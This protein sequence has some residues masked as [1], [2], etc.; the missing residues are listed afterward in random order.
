MASVYVTAVIDAPVDR[1]W[2]VIRDFNALPKWH[3]FVESSHIEDGL[4]SALVGCI[5]NFQLKNDGGTI[6]EQLLT[7]SDTERSVQYSILDSP[8][9][10]SNYVAKLRVIGITTTNQ[11]LGEWAASFDVPT[12]GEAEAIGAVTNIFE[13]GF[14]QV[15]KLLTR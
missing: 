6:R 1:V 7:L 9:P 11:T 5:R 3:P 4:P 15:N 8:L 2:E 10:V 13:E 12:D 14:S